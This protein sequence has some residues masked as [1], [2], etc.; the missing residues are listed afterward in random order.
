[1]R[2]AILT[3]RYWCERNQNQVRSLNFLRVVNE[4]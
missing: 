1:M 3:C 2:R 4:Q